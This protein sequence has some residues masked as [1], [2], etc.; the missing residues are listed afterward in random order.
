MIRAAHHLVTMLGVPQTSRGSVWIPT[1]ARATQPMR[2][3]KTHAHRGCS[4]ACGSRGGYKWM[5]DP[6]WLQGFSRPEV[7]IGH[8]ALTDSHCQTGQASE[9]SLQ[10]RCVICGASV[11]RAGTTAKVCC[12]HRPMPEGR[13]SYCGGGQMGGL[14]RCQWRPQLSA[15]ATTDR[16]VDVSTVSISLGRRSDWRWC[17]PRQLQGGESRS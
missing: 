16:R 8:G 9:I 3:A 14:A 12:Q 7:T 10:R 15:K 5:G 4:Q 1:S 13:F 2:M 17:M 6:C 11:A